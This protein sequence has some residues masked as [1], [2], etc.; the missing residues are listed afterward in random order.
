MHTPSSPTELWYSTLTPISDHALFGD[1]PRAPQRPFL[2][3]RLTRLV[4]PANL[5]AMRNVSAKT[6]PHLHPSIR[7]LGRR[8]REE[9]L[10]RGWALA[11]LAQRLRV[12]KGYL[13]RLERGKAKPARK[14]IERLA[15]A[16]QIDPNPLLGLAAY[17][18]T[19][20]KEILYRYPIEAPAV[21]R[22][23][24]DGGSYGM[25][26][27]VTV[28]DRICESRASYAASDSL[29]ELVHG[30]C[31][32]W[33]EKRAAKSIHAVVTDPPYGLK[34]YT[35]EEK[36]KLRRGKGG[37]WR[38]PPTLDGCTRRPLPRFTVLTEEEKVA[39]RKFFSRWAFKVFRVLVPGGHVFIAS[40]PLLSHLVYIALIEGGFEKRGE[41]IRLV[42]TLRAGDRPKNAHKEFD[43]VTVMPR[44]SWE[45]WGL[46]RKPCEGRVQDNLRK[47]KTG[48]LRRIGKDQPFSDVIR[49]SPTRSTE[50]EIAPH[51][52]LKP[53]GFMRQIVRAA[54]P[55]GEGIV[56][57]PFMGAGSTITAACAVG[58]RSIGIEIDPEF[59]S[60]AVKAVPQL[61]AVTINGNGSEQPQ[62]DED[63]A[64]RRQQILFG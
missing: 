20:V 1:Q 55:L 64:V 9:R 40:N 63:D 58:Y 44:S 61:A 23:A 51:P 48:G 33:L 11:R 49:S 34:E 47:W 15:K 18:P 4:N 19:D 52:S 6:R 60:M 21:L 13:S 12:S 59:Y 26:E 5:W 32:E 37:V 36:A 35:S 30:D 62:R 8:L 28:R 25:E 43:E 16:W 54:L 50:R 29:Y 31:F 57:D 38:I 14:M 41:I 24:F 3:E 45:P 39:L 27:T 56:L 22:E 42:Q 53:Q 10:A 7:E 17:L 2:S 46:F